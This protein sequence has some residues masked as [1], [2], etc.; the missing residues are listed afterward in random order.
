MVKAPNISKKWRRSCDPS[1]RYTRLSSCGRSCVFVRPRPRS[2]L[3]K[4]LLD[5]IGSSFCVTRPKRQIA[6]SRV[7]PLE[8]AAGQHQPGSP[9]SPVRP[10]PH[11]SHLIRCTLG[12]METFVVI[13]VCLLCY[14]ALDFVLQCAN[15]SRRDGEDPASLTS[16]DVL[17]SEA[18]QEI[19]T[20]AG[21]ANTVHQSSL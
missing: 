12:S 4:V 5:Q 16:V 13:G 14:Q 2:I 17:E 8:F 10:K 11:T 9:S 6:V 15:S 19:Y 7:P 18:R 20:V 3:S 1:V 21:N